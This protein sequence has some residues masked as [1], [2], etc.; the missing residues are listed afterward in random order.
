MDIPAIILGFVQANPN[1]AAVLLAMGV[2]RAV[3]KPIFALAHAYV[4]ATASPDDDAELAKIE[5]SKIVKA[6]AFVLDYVASV[7]IK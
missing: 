4:E 3:F 7:K 6:I 5:D 2:A 1:A